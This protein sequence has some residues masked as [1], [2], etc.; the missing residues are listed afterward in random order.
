MNIEQGEF[1]PQM[2]IKRC[3]KPTFVKNMNAKQLFTN[4]SEP[5]SSA[6]PYFRNM[7]GSRYLDTSNTAEESCCHIN[8]ADD[9]TLPKTQS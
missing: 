6:Q 1:L 4:T 7:Q 2:N 5:C 8:I 3:E 9:F